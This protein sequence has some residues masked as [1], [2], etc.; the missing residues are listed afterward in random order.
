MI[1]RPR[2]LKIW[3]DPEQ[4]P[5]PGAKA[6]AGA[7]VL[8]AVLLVAVQGWWVLVPA[9]GV[10]SGA[11]VVDVAPHQG[12]FDVARNLEREGVIR[13]PLGFVLLSVL[14]GSARRLK[15]GEYEIP[16]NATTLLILS[17]L[18]D[19][20]LKKHTILFSE[21]STVQDLARRLEAEGLA[22]AADV[23]RL[24]RDV[25]FLRTIGVEVDALEGYLFPDTYHFIKGMAAEE[26]LARMVQRLR[27]QVTPEIL[28]QAALRE[29]TLHQ[30]LTLASIIE[31]EAVAPQELPLISAVFWNR[32]RREMLLQA[33]PTVRYA[34][35]KD[36]QALTRA[37]LLVDS[38]FNTYRVPGLPPGPIASPGKA[39]ILA[40]LHPAPVNY[41][42]FVSTGDDRRHHFSVTLDQHNS[43]VARYRLARA[44]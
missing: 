22:S 41:L 2:V 38:P 29:L 27:E 18:E 3:A 43:A 37:D 13:S 7:A 14:R 9:P 8:G 21:G 25:K 35:G 30:L 12:V 42:Y 28:A 39:A 31:K 19:G 40:A 6:V 23:M 15:A 1:E 44:K 33:D 17:L 16:Q 24:S 11:R 32:L 5:G 34:V 10:Q 36:R 20:R 26:M 4:R